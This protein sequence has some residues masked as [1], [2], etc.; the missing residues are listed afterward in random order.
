MHG[1]RFYIKIKLLLVLILATWLTACQPVKASILA[2]TA[3]GTSCTPDTPAPS[4]TPTNVPPKF[5][6]T[7]TPVPPTATRALPTATASP[8]LTSTPRGALTWEQQRLLDEISLRFTADTAEEANQLVR[9]EIDYLPGDVEDASLM[10]GPFAAYLLREIGL[11]PADTRLRDFWLLNPRVQPLHI[12]L[13][14][15]F[16]EEYFTWYHFDTQWDEVDYNAFPLLPGDF[17]YLYAGRSGTFDHMIVV[18][19]VDEAGRAYT[20]SNINSKV[21]FVIRPMM[22]YDPTQPGVGQI[23]DWD[24]FAVSRKYGMTGSGGFEL[25]RLTSPMPTPLPKE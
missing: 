16:P 7:P 12:T 6:A 4:A 2:T 5:T 20:V 19:R 25:L 23:Y 22:L 17:L 11:L 8:T 24:N 9:Q 21:G 13:S 10:C 14:K 1:I 3:P 18:T 15:Y